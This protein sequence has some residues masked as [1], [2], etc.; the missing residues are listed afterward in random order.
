MKS[1]RHN[2]PGTA[3]VH[4]EQNVQII[5]M[6]SPYEECSSAVRDCGE[7]LDSYIIPGTYYDRTYYVTKK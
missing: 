3:L 2:E 5:L 7:T 1:L 6:K 4:G